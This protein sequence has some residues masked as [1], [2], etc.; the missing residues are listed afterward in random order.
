M[1]TDGSRFKQVNKKTAEWLKGKGLLDE[2]VPAEK[3]DIGE[4][5]DLKKTSGASFAAKKIIK[6]YC[7]LVRKKPYEKSPL[8]TSFV[9][10]NNDPEDIIG[11]G[12]IATLK[13]NKNAQIAVKKITKKYKDIPQKKKAKTDDVDFAIT[14]FKELDD[15]DIDF[16]VSDSRPVDDTDDIDFTITNSKVIT[17][18]KNQASK[19]LQQKTPLKNIVT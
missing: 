15:D 7:N 12:D 3:A 1:F 13:P 10:E 19:T 4:T 6:K 2:N 16:R 14:D 11:L 17:N 5:I 18:T 9:E 8:P